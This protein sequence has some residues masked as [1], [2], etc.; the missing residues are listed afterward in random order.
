MRLKEFIEKYGEEMLEHFMP[1]QLL[2]KDLETLGWN[3]GVLVYLN[4]YDPTAPEDIVIINSNFYTEG[5]IMAV[6]PKSYIKADGETLFEI[7]GNVYNNT[8]TAALQEGRDIVYN[9]NNWNWKIEKE[10][11][12]TTLDGKFINVFSKFENCPNNRWLK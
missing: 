4:I 2:E 10:W 12:I 1:R 11:R 5:I 9:I 7:N 3:S 8:R 6:S